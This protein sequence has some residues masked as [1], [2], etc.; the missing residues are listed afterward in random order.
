[1]NKDE[2]WVIINPFHII[3]QL[4]GERESIVQP[5]YVTLARKSRNLLSG[6]GH[7]SYGKGRN[8]LNG[9]SHRS[10]GT[11]RNLLSGQ[12]YRSHGKGRSFGKGRNL[13]V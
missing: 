6:Q 4:L 8:L 1:M 9:Q 12:G 13:G 2:D 10:Y 11:G 3:R 5:A 7:R